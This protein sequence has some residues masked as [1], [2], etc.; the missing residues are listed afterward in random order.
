MTIDQ[1]AAAAGVSN[2]T[3]SRAMAGR[4]VRADLAE[5]VLAAAAE[6][7]YQP[8]RAAQAIASGTYQMIGVVVPDVQNPYFS[9][10]LKRITRSA[11]GS[12]YRVLVADANDDPGEEFAL[13]RSLLPQVDGLVLVSPRMP[14]TDLRRLAEESGRMVLVN[15]GPSGVA[16]PTIT[17]DAFAATM[18][19]CGLL[20]GLGHRDVVYL[21]GPPAAWQE[22]QR[23][24]A[25]QHAEAFGLGARRLAGGSTV[26][27]GYRVAEEALATGAS[28]IVAFNDL[29]AIGVVHRL[30]E[31][32]VDVPGRVS[33]TGAD[34]IP[35]AACLRPSLTTTRSPRDELGDATWD[36]LVAAMAGESPEPPAL[37]EPELVVRDSTGPAPGGGRAG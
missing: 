11:G 8:N 15:R 19:V 36:A 20:V 5:R 27:D 32:G 22:Q 10:V 37:P 17:V 7:G 18:K 12:G 34:D 6:L 24:R 30:L 33:V 21:G 14:D 28:A 23:W 3:V 1:V 13:A 16:L 4:P 25:L 2:A 26:E 35:F 9:G 29:L 31:L